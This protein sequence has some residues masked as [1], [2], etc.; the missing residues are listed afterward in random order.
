MPCKLCDGSNVRR[1]FDASNTHGRHIID[2]KEKFEIYRC[3][4]CEVLYIE[5]IVVDDEYY[6]KCYP[7]G[8]YN[9]EFNNNL[10]S[11]LLNLMGRITIS[12]KVRQILKYF[13][14]KHNRL[15]ILD[16][17]CGRGEFLSSL[18]DTDFDKYGLEINPAGYRI[19]KE[20][21]IKA[22]NRQ[23]KDLNFQGDSFDIITLWHV[24]EHLKEP[25]ETILS[26]KKILKKD[27]VLVV[28]TPNTDSLGFR[29]GKSSWFHL[30]SPRHL[31]LYNLRSLEYL[32]HKTG[33]KIIRQKNIFYDFPLD[34]FWSVR[35]S[36]VKYFIYPLYPVFKFLSKETILFICRQ[37]YF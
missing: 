13:P 24:I 30:D 20:Q 25:K 21:G 23:L 8:Y 3:A 33:F 27:G 36:R 2:N 5:D 1:L 15:K 14:K 29:Y 26:I 19:C 22:Y 18:S 9:T 34:L 4:D 31:I 12:A 32:L 11:N 6:F 7:A 28:A 35:K 16:I 37:G 10:F 17:G